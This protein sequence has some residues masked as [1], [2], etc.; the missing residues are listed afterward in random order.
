MN[1]NSISNNTDTIVAVATAPG[2]GGVGVVR[3][4]GKDLSPFVDGF[5]GEKTTL[6]PR[7]AY[8]SSFLDADSNPLDQG[9]ALYFPAPHSFTGEHVPNPFSGVYRVD[10]HGPCVTFAIVLLSESDQACVPV[11]S[12]GSTVSKEICSSPFVT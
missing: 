5:L 8:Y 10:R 4:S 9:L 2:R 6:K 3:I 7:Q 12:G 1:F 11:V